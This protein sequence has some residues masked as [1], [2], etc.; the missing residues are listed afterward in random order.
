ML[1]QKTT[2]KHKNKFESD[3]LGTADR[4]IIDRTEVYENLLTFRN[5]HWYQCICYRYRNIA[6]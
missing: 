4:N 2:Q 6:D 1:S 5:K 3:F